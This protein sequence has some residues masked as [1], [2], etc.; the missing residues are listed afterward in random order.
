MSNEVQGALPNV[1]S[2]LCPSLIPPPSKLVLHR[3]CTLHDTK[4]VYCL[5]CLVKPRP[6]TIMK[7]VTVL[8]SVCA[9]ILPHPSAP[10][11]TRYWSSQSNVK[12]LNPN[13]ESIW[14]GL[15]VRPGTKED[16][17]TIRRTLA[18]MLMNPLFINV[19]NF[20]C[21]EEDGELVG[22]GQVNPFAPTAYLQGTCTN[23]GNAH[24]VR[25]ASSFSTH[26]CL[27]G[28]PN[29]LPAAST[30]APFLQT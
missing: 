15:H 2:G 12:S 19:Q 4:T 29:F 16:E 30:P 7:G 26:T 28:T 27:Q 11:R 24:H 25:S 13:S 21:A 1:N 8:G 6:M 22:F 3:S 23:T 9:F 14:E 10:P 5:C 20:V 18:G 17:G